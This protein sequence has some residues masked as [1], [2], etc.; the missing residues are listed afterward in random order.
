[1]TR[2]TASVGS[3]ATAIAA[4]RR[5]SDVCERPFEVALA[6]S[7]NH[8]LPPG[9]IART[10]G[11]H[12]LTDFP[13]LGTYDVSVAAPSSDV[14]YEAVIEFKWWGAPGSRGGPPAKR[15][16]T[17]WD[18]LKVACSIAGRRTKRG[19]LVVLAPAAS[20]RLSH[21]FAS[22]FDGGRWHTA[23]LCSGNPGAMVY[24]DEAHYGV[25]RVPASVVAIPVATQ[26]VQDACDASDWLLKTIAI[27]PQGSAEL[28]TDHRPASGSL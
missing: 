12:G 24:F 28:L 23:E 8:E 20:W 19:Y 3:R 16:E 6:E 26:A 22:L 7:L 1:M 15:H 27:E 2:V 14:P 11:L 13:R 5:L 17:L 21:D 18:L 4:P 10:G 9:L 25:T